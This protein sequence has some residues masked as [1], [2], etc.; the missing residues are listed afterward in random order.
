LTNLS[1]G[2]SLEQ[3]VAQTGTKPRHQFSAFLGTNEFLCVRII[4]EKPKGPLYFLFKDGK[5]LAIK[6]PPKVEFETKYYADGTPQ[7]TPK[8]IDTEK[9]VNEILES[10]A[11]SPT[12]ILERLRRWAA[13]GAGAGKGK[14]PWNILPAILIAS[15]FMLAKSPSINQANEEAK[16]LAAT[17]DPFKVRL[18]MGTNEVR[19]LFGEPAQRINFSS[20]CLWHIYGADLPAQASVRNPPV[21]ILVAFCDGR[22]NRI[23]SD[24]FVDKRRFGIR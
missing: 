11:L 19:E 2:I 14:E 22:V 23:F 21:W 10:Q 4:F 1:R 17:F 18:G 16:R 9:R 7:K 15:P 3:L 12:D 24:V 13:D 6:D 8:P 20:N 5:L